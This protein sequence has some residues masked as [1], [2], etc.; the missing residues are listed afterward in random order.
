MNRIPPYG[1][2]TDYRKIDLFRRRSG[3]PGWY[4]CGST[5]WAHS[6]RFAVDRYLACTGAERGTVKAHYAKVQS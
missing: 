3:V 1:S 2:K 4:Y 5:T 6:C